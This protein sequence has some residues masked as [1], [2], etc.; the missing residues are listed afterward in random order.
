M[1]EFRFGIVG[2][3]R[4]AKRHSEILGNGLISGARL[5]AVCDVQADRANVMADKFGVH[6]FHSLD[7]MLK[8]DEVDVVTVLTPSGMHAEHAIAAANAGKHVVVEKPMALR[9]DD[10]D[11]MIAACDRARV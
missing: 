9:L 5:T 10:A 8:S 2:C 11:A 3:G 1:S 6:S 7:D 4:I